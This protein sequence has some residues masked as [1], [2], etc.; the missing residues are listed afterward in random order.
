MCIAEKTTTIYTITILLIIKLNC[1]I[2]L[3]KSQF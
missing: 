1:K 3:F 2:L